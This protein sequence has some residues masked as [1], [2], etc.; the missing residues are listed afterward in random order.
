MYPYVPNMKKIVTFPKWA[1]PKIPEM[2]V[3]QKQK[4][5]RKLHRHRGAFQNLPLENKFIY[6]VISKSDVFQKDALPDGF[7]SAKI[8]FPGKSK[9]SVR[10]AGTC[11]AIWISRTCDPTSL[12]STKTVEK[13]VLR[14]EVQLLKVVSRSKLYERIFWWFSSLFQLNFH[15]CNASI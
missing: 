4:R 3:F 2:S 9:W 10:S 8:N 7:L 6:K 12:S 1:C 15:V 13:S 11:L 14:L 5:L